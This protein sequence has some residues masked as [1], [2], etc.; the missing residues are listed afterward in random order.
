[1]S[2]EDQQA[3][4]DDISPNEFAEVLS[5]LRS[6]PRSDQRRWGEVYV[7]G[8]LA[9][10]GKKTMRA[11]ANGAGSGAEQS[12]YQF[13]SKSPWDVDA[14]RGDLARLL[15][16]RA[17]PRAWVVQPLV[18]TKVGQHSV[19]VERQWVSQIG[20][21]VNCQQAM[22][23]WLAGDRGSCPVDW[24]LALPECWTDQEDMR[25]RASIPADVASC[26]PEQCA[27]DS[28]SKMAQE[29]GLRG[30]PVVMDL[31]ETSPQPV[32]AELVDR[33]IPFV[34]R[35]DP[36][37]ITPVPPGQKTAPGGPG[38]A[39]QAGG[40]V[41]SAGLLSALH[42]QRM[43]VEWFDHTEQTMRATSVGAARVALRKGLTVHGQ[44]ERLD[45]VLLAA[46]A[47]PRRRSPS[48]FWLSNLAQSQLGTV[49]RTAMLSRRVERDLA[50]VSDGL[51]IRDFEGRSYRGWHH[52]MTMVSLAHAVTVLSPSRAQGPPAPKGRSTHVP[53]REA[54][55]SAA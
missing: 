53:S 13:I 15:I 44:P 2:A 14:V 36:S 19:G 6:I 33:Q 23:V 55:V 1:M 42:K 27:V 12:L 30:R 11:L 46:W 16:E 8:L 22:S 4:P 45:L 54:K 28:V 48:E 43:P 50:E 34:V 10:R 49:Y 25:R 51:G 29:W 9:V 7:R 31:R 5:A 38:P 17:Q 39:D 3:L 20:R 41:G 52:H 18:I 40:W 32:C 35:V 47:D 26:P 21:V 24:Q 37:S